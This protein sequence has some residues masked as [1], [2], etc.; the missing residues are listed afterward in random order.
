MQEAMPKLHKDLYHTVTPEAL[1]AAFAKLSAELPG[2]NHDQIV[3]RLMQIGAMVRDGHSGVSVNF[4]PGLTHVALLIGRY[5]DGLFVRSAP[6]TNAAIVGA[7]VVA[8]G[9]VDWQETLRRVDTV[10]SCDPGNDGQR[11][12]WQPQVLLTDPMVL[13]GLGLSGSADEVTYSLEKD[14]RR[15]DVTLKPSVNGVDLFLFG[16]PADWVDAQKAPGPQPIAHPWI[17]PLELA[18]VPAAKAIYVQFNEV[19]RPKGETVTAFVQRLETMMQTVDADRLVIDVRHNSGGDNTLLR[20]L[21]ISVI[22]SKFNR[23]GGLFVLIGPTTFSAAENF[24]N[25]IESYTEAIFVGEPTSQNVN[26]FGDPRELVLPNSHLEVEMAHLWWQDKDPRDL[27][28]ATSPQIAIDTGTF[29]DYVAGRDAALEYCLHAP[30][31][32]TFGES[33][34]RAAANGHDQALAQYKAYAADPAHRYTVG[35]LEGLLNTLGYQALSE[36]K[37]AD[38]LVLFQVNA[39]VHPGSANVFDSLGDGFVAVADAPHAIAAYKRSVE[40][41]PQNH[42]AAQEVERLEKA[43][44]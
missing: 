14:G 9:G 34:R 2:L 10:I 13:H 40:L 22:R 26:S 8:I 35:D 24:T 16:A 1:N 29:A 7:R 5:P 37:P 3:V 43:G 44:K 36:N 6:V 12:A 4:R 31:P 21:L 38:A 23:R 17:E 41:D 30:T 28:T 20:P 39:E 42:H 18:Y 33:M 19:A 32:P 15:F 11:F 25:R 27:R